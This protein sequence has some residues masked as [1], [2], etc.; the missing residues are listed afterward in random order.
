MDAD[1]EC[2]QAHNLWRLLRPSPFNAYACPQLHYSSSPPQVLTTDFPARL[3]R[4]NRGVRFY[5]LVHEH[6]EDAPGKSIARPMMLH[7]VQFLHGGYIDEPTRRARYS[8]NLPLL[9]RDV[10]ESPDRLINQFLLVRD[11]AQGLQFA[12]QLGDVDRN[13]ARLQALRGVEIVHKMIANPDFPL[14]MV[15]DSLQYYSV[16][17]EYL[18]A[19]FTCKFNWTTAMPPFEAMSSSGAVEARFHDRATYLNLLDRIAK[20]TTKHYESKYC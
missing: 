13:D 1:E 3:F 15:L 5:G 19:G 12:L 4:A 14:R 17:N 2:P 9:L 7:D 11:Y 20:E 16:L 8:R 6:P 18:G 10:E